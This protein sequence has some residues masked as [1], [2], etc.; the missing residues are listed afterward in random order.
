MYLMFSGSFLSFIVLDHPIA[1]EPSQQELLF[2]VLSMRTICFGGRS[3]VLPPSK[4]IIRLIFSSRS[5]SKKLC[6]YSQI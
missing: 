6:K 5:H 1:Q 3:V 2:Y 4:I